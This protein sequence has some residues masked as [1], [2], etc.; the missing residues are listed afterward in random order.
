MLQIFTSYHAK[1]KQ[2]KDSGFCVVNISVKFPPFADPKHYAATVKKLAPTYDMLKLSN[3]EY[4]K[5]FDEIL[6]QTSPAEIFLELEKI[7]MQSG[8]GKVALLCYE[9]DRNTCHRSYVGDWIA[10]GLGIIVEEVNFDPPKKE[11]IKQEPPKPQEPKKAN[12][13]ITQLNLF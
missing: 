11:P 9:K 10:N 6:A 5:R 3:L 8:S 12:P 4:R 2:L 7:A 13:S 1:A